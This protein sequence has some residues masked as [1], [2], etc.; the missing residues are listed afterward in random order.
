MNSLQAKSIGRFPTGRYATRADFC[1]IFK[2]KVDSLYLLALLLT[3]ESEAAEQCFLASF[4]DCIRADRVFKDWAYSWAKLA[5]IKNVMSEWQAPAPNAC[6]PGRNLIPAEC[7][8]GSSNC[9]L[10]QVLALPRFLRFVFVLSVLER[11]S[12]RDC[13]L[14]L[15]SSRNDVRR[16]R[17]MALQSIANVSPPTR[18]TASANPRPGSF[19]EPSLARRA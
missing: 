10:D 5:I 9:E 4:E 12:E 7:C 14:L 15:S 19:D 16:A 11:H 17:I 2:G 13:A 1:S 18:E 8:K 6:E 3:G